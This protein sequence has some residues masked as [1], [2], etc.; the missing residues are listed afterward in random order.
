M[1]MIKRAKP[2]TVEIGQYWSYIGLQG[3]PLHVLDLQL[4]YGCST[5]CSYPEKELWAI[6]RKNKSQPCYDLLNNSRWIYYGKDEEIK[7]NAASSDKVVTVPTFPT[8]AFPANV[9]KVY[10]K[11]YLSNIR[12]P[13]PE[14]AYVDLINKKK[15][16]TDDDSIGLYYI[17]A[18]G[19]EYQTWIDFDDNKPFKWVDNRK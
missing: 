17:N 12:F 11:H 9:W 1:Y 8:F 14:E 2:K 4:K 13:T 10:Y 15:Y 5:R 18:I 19:E 3:K 6:F 7:M 16:L